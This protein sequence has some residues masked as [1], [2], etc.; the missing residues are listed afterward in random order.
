MVEHAD[1]RLAADHDAAQ[2]LIAETGADAS[3][4]AA[5]TDGLLLAAWST[6]AATNLL[7]HRWGED[8]VVFVHR[9]GA[10]HWLSAG[11]VVVFDLLRSMAVHAVC[12]AQLASALELN[13]AAE[14]AD[15]C[16]CLTQLESIGLVVRHAQAS[17]R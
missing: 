10:T 12:T 11:Q 9:S 5:P 13:C 4:R 16:G 8:V 3:L 17:A 2:R 6:D 14:I 15:L 7:I 1:R